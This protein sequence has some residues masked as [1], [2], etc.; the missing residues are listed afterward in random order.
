MSDSQEFV[1]YQIL[2]TFCHDWYKSIWF[3]SPFLNFTSVKDAHIRFEI[4]NVI[5]SNTLCNIVSFQFIGNW[6]SDCKI[7]YKLTW[8]NPNLWAH[9][10]WYESNMLAYW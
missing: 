1:I 2:I 4:T 7:E 9:L 3:N 5:H 8:L 10:I 6:V